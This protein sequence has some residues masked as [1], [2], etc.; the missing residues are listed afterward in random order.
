MKIKLIVI[1]S[2]V[3]FLLF[4]GT[5]LST[6][7]EVSSHFSNGGPYFTADIDV[8][9]SGDQTASLTRFNDAFVSPL[10]VTLDG[11]TYNAYCID[12]F[13]PIWTSTYNNYS[14]LT[15]DDYINNDYN[16]PRNLEFA[17]YNMYMNRDFVN[18][19]TTMTYSQLNLWDTLYDFY[20]EG[21]SGY[22]NQYFDN[23]FF[24]TDIN[25]HS[26]VGLNP[27]DDAFVV[28]NQVH[29][30]VD[31]NPNNTYKTTVTNARSNDSYSD[32]TDNYRV[33][34]FGNGEGIQELII[35]YN[36]V[37]EP[38]TMMLFGFGLIAIAKVGR[39]KN[40]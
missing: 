9:A 21:D 1:L 28:F 11:V 6:P 34:Q 29:T 23:S 39:R 22:A 14:I 19:L 12:I 16:D 17:L 25:R 24:A 10:I 13:D 5:S 35:E 31:G 15:V 27:Y 4:T 20:P 8:R 32:I 33:I 38:T 36:N 2:M 30:G 26:D 40:V 18:D 3:M 37:P 7:I